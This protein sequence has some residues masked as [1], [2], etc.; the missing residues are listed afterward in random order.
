M[1]RANGEGCIR[2][3]KGNRKKPY[4][5]LVTTYNKETKKQTFKSLGTYETYEQAE[6]IITEYNIQNKKTLQELQESNINTQEHIK[7]LYDYLAM[8]N[9]KLNKL[10]NINDNNKITIQD[11]YTCWQ[12]QH[13]K[14]VS[15]NT[16]KYYYTAFKNMQTLHNK[17]INDLKLNDLQIYCDTLTTSKQIAF[18]LLINQLY[19]YAIAN[20]YVTKNYSNYLVIKKATEKRTKN[21]FTHEEIESILN[22]KTFDIYD[23]ITLIL[24][25]TGM[26]I[27]ELFNLQ[28]NDCNF[29]DKIITIKAGKTKSA[30]RK[31]PIHEKII[32]HIEYLYNNSDSNYLI[33]LHNKKITQATYRK[34]LKKRYNNH[35]P[36]EIRHTF[37]T[38]CKK[39]KL[40]PYITKL[41]LGHTTTDLTLNT[42]T[43]LTIKEI[44]EE[45]KKFN[46]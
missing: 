14:N 43:H 6:R 8:I 17:Y 46:Y 40:D 25:Y 1:K 31:I 34:K 9:T 11:L 7:N 35:I 38:Q 28:K 12:K 2:K 20:D 5:A 32:N 39:C 15:K 30:R 41:I 24:L 36:H 18:R 16:K 45:F 13:F 27:S 19:K 3:L 4:Q 10:C 23:R 29:K 26:R 37:A 33:S 42:Y 22:L 44:Q 21:I